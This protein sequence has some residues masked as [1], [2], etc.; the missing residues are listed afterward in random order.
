M[1]LYAVRVFVHDWV[2]SRHF[3]REV[4][5]LNEEFAAEEF[6]WAEFDLGGP[7]LGIE[8]I[9]DSASQADSALV[10]RFLGVSIMVDDVWGHYRDLS[11]KGVEFCAEPQLQPW[12]GTLV[13]FLDNS[14]NTL[15]LMSENKDS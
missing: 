4:L 3:Y 7:K 2:A 10:G 1:K 5:G 8:R 6:G 13:H 15:T 11:A 12:G 9:D 14:G